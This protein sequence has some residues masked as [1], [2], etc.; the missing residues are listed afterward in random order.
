MDHQGQ[1][2]D[3]RQHCACAAPGFS[4]TREGLQGVPVNKVIGIK[5]P[6]EAF[7]TA[8]AE[9]TADPPFESTPQLVT[10]RTPDGTARLANAVFGARRDSL[11]NDGDRVLCLTLSRLDLLNVVLE[12][13]DDGTLR[14]IHGPVHKHVGRRAEVLLCQPLSAIVPGLGGRI[15]LADDLLVPPGHRRAPSN[16]RKSV[17]GPEHFQEQ[18]AGSLGV[19]LTFQAAR[20]QGTKDEVLALLEATGPHPGPARPPEARAFVAG[21]DPTEIDD[22]LPGAQR[23]GEG[24]VIDA[25]AGEGARVA[26]GAAGAVTGGMGGVAKGAESE[27]ETGAGAG[28]VEEGKVDGMSKA[29]EGAV[30]GGSPDDGAKGNVVGGKHGD[31]DGNGDDESD[32]DDEGRVPPRGSA[33]ERVREWVEAGG[34]LDRGSVAM[35][36][37]L[38]A[39]ASLTRPGLLQQLSGAANGDAGVEPLTVDA[40]ARLQDSLH[41]MKAKPS[42]SGDIS[43]ESAR[44]LTA[45]AWSWLRIHVNMI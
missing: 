13:A 11:G 7:M 2:Q 28:E 27:G 30:D 8:W 25:G 19:R 41:L 23:A 29:A 21:E 32:S 20:M 17:V 34:S 10:V 40:I 36:V 5:G 24:L 39:T 14:A 1:V 35:S 9:A 45:A 4:F 16:K 33:Y 15:H 43:R 42:V 3:V 18:Y 6:L 38:S 37:G 22:A 31:G 26:E 44:A 12:M